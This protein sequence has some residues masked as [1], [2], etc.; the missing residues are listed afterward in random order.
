MVARM[1]M[2]VVIAGLFSTFIFYSLPQWKFGR[3]VFLIQMMV[4]WGL[5]IGWR[6]VFGTLIME[7]AEK[8]NVLIFGAGEA[9]KDL[10]E[11][12]N[13]KSSPYNV[14]GFLDDDPAKLGTVIGSPRVLGKTDQVIKIAAS[15]GVKLAILAITHERSPRLI[16]DI[17]H[18]RLKGGINIIESPVV[19][20][21][22][23]G[24]IPVHHIHDGWL[25]FA[26]GFNLISKAYIWKIKRLLDFWISLLLLL[27]TFPVMVITALAIRL[28]SPG[29]VIFKQKRVG[30]NEQIFSILKFRSMKKDAEQ[31][32][33]VWAEKNDPRITRVGR[34][35]RLLRIDE[36]PQ[37]LNVFRG[38]MS[39]IGPRPERPE[40]VLDL[41]TKIPYYDIRH[42]IR[43]GIT[44]WAQINYSYGA[45]LEDAHRKLEY[46]IYYIKNMSL[47]LDIK[48]LLKTIGVVLFGQ[49]AR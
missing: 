45:S 4:V 41:E 49:G 40:F 39:L 9:G 20:E 5:L 42:Y 16:Q 21:K 6:Y 33:A 2:A 48:I 38:E 34:W 11:L 15:Q 23:I 18:A 7:R 1:V 22:L 31:N 25:L 47:I 19:Y 3:S 43:P 27:M 44:G 26:N 13:K 30:M 17:L 14:V 29:P 8:T 36:L 28:D 10:Y 24:C 12:L 32:G 37:L 46:D 35:I